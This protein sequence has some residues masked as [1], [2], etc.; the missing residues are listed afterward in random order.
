MNSTKYMVY[1]DLI[2][3]TIVDAIANKKPPTHVYKD[4]IISTIVDS[5]LLF[6]RAHVYKDLIIST[7][8]DK[9]LMMARNYS[10]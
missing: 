3:S 8:V 2:I 10:L 4:L 7:I 5:C 9:I 6:S 1:K